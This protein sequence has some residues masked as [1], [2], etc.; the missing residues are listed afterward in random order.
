MGGV[1]NRDSISMQLA[2]GEYSLIKAHVL[3][4]L[5]RVAKLVGSERTARVLLNELH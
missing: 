4:A 3:R 2:Q 1:S 5:C